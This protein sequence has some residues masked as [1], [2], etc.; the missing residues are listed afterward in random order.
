M[1]AVWQWLFIS[2][3]DGAGY[4]KPFDNDMF[5][6]IALNY[7]DGRAERHRTDRVSSTH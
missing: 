7:D 6:Q 3:I 5:A 1:R 2:V 4:H